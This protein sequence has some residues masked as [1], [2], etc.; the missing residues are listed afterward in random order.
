[1]TE[2]RIGSTPEADDLPTDG[3]FRDVDPDEKAA[4]R[5]V[6]SPLEALRLQLAEPVVTEPVKLKVPGRPGIVCEF[7][8]NM[9]DD[10]RKAWQKRATKRRRGREDEIDDM[11]YSS[12]ILANTH[13]GTYMDG[14]EVRDEEG[15][16]VTFRHR[17]L[18]TM[19]GAN[20]PMEAIRKFYGIDAHVL[21]ASGEVLLASGFDDDMTADPTDEPEGV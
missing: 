15:T 14:V 8:T 7:R 16:A 20:E 19:V 17:M 18:H 3:P 2:F 10:D 9:E 12:L 21:I 1:M 11:Y 4:A 5:A 6:V 13:I